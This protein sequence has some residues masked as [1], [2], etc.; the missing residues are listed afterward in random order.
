MFNGSG[1]IGKGGD[2]GIEGCGGG[3]GGGGSLLGSSANF[4]GSPFIKS[5]R[6]RSGTFPKGKKATAVEVTGAW[7]LCV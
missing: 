6:A 4:S 3:G 1:C 5:N 2:W 7:E